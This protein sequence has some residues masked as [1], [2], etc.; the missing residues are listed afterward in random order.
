MLEPYASKGACTVLRGGGGGD[1]TSLPDR[2]KHSETSVVHLLKHTPDEL[3]I[4][5]GRPSSRLFAGV[6][7]AIGAGLMLLFVATISGELR[8][9]GATVSNGVGGP[10]CGC[11]FAADFLI[12][13]ICLFNAA[14]DVQCTFDGATRMLRRT[15]GSAV[16]DIPFD[17][18]RQAAV[19]EGDEGGL[20]LQ[21]QFTDRDPLQLSDFLTPDRSQPA[22]AAQII[23][24]F[25]AAHP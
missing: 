23:N 24:D 21:L 20:G 13:G 7:I 11:L 8:K 3:V 1:A 25:L 4:H 6:F 5:C 16:E 10:L 12:P 22:A 17:R 14:R 19:Q 18:I 15:V 9:P 2:R